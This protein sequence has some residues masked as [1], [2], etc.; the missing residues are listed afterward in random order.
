M[1]KNTIHKA[2]NAFWAEKINLMLKLYKSR[3]YLHKD[4]YIPGRV[5][6][7]FSLKYTS[8]KA[9]RLVT[10]LHLTTG[11]YILQTTRNNFN[12]HQVDGTSSAT[13]RRNL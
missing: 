13:Q 9:A 12:Q 10:K 5:H 2:V 4:E 1:W 8:R 6:P 11:T 3:K 7:L